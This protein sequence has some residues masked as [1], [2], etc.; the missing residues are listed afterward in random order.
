MNDLSM[1]AISAGSNILN[2][3]VSTRAKERS[4]D[5]SRSSMDADANGK[6]Y[7]EAVVDGGNL[8]GVFSAN[9]KGLQNRSNI[10]NISTSNILFGTP[11]D[12]SIFYSARKPMT[13]PIVESEEPETLEMLRI[14]ISKVLSLNGS[15]E[16]YPEEENIINGKAPQQMDRAVIL[17]DVLTMLQGVEEQLE[18]VTGAGLDI[19]T[20]RR[21]LLGGASISPV[22]KENSYPNTPM[23][24][25]SAETETHKDS[26]LLKIYMD[27][28]LELNQEEL[29]HY[30]K[31]ANDLVERLENAHTQL[32]AKDATISTLEAAHEAQAA[33]LA[34]VTSDLAQQNASS[35]ELQQSAVLLQNQVHD[36]TAR[37]EAT[38]R[39]RPDAALV[40]RMRDG[41]A[42]PAL[43][44]EPQKVDRSKALLRVYM[45]NQLALDVSEMQY[46][47]DVANDLIARL[48][49][50]EEAAAEDHRTLQAQ[51]D[52]LTTELREAQAEQENAQE[53]LD[54]AREE[55]ARAVH[56]RA[57]LNAARAELEQMYHSQQRLAA[58]LHDTA[59]RY[60]ESD[61]QH[62]VVANAL[63]SAQHEIQAM[64]TQVSEMN[65]LQL[66]LQRV[67][68]DLGH[69]HSALSNAEARLEAATGGHDATQTALA[70]SQRNVLVLQELLEQ[71]RE[72]DVMNE[73]MIQEL[74][75]M[76]EEGEEQVQHLRNQLQASAIRSTEVH[77][78]SKKL[79]AELKAARESIHASEVQRNALEAEVTTVREQLQHMA[80]TLSTDVSVLTGRIDV[81]QR[82]KDEA[83]QIAETHL[84]TL[85]QRNAELN[86]AHA[87]A[88][89]EIKHRASL[90][91]ELQEVIRS[92]HSA[93]QP[94]S[95]MDHSQADDS[96]R[97]NNPFVTVLDEDDSLS[98][99]SSHTR[100]FIDG[101]E[102]LAGPVSS[103]D[104]VSLT[105]RLEEAER[106]AAQASANGADKVASSLRQAAIADAECS[107]LK[108]LGD[109]FK[110]VNHRLLEENRVAR[111]QAVRVRGLELQLADV[112]KQVT[113]AAA[114]HE[115]AL[116]KAHAQRQEQFERF[117]REREALAETRAS[118]EKEIAAFRTQA[119]AHAAEASR[120]SALLLAA[121]DESA[122]LDR[123]NEVLQGEVGEAREEVQRHTQ[124][125]AALAATVHAKT[126]ELQA[127]EL[128][129]HSWK[130]EK[131]SLH[132]DWHAKFADL[133]DD[134]STLEGVH[135][136]QTAQTAELRR[137]IEQFEKHAE[138]YAA[139]RAGEQRHL[140]EARAKIIELQ[141]TKDELILQLSSADEELSKRYTSIQ[142]LSDEA[143]SWQ[144]KAEES[145]V[146]SAKL[147][148]LLAAAEAADTAARDTAWKAQQE[149]HARSNDV[150][151]AQKLAAEAEA[152]LR[153]LEAELQR[154][155]QE[156]LVQLQDAN[157]RTDKHYRETSAAYTDLRAQ[158]D[159]L[160]GESARLEAEFASLR[161]VEQQQITLVRAAE[162]RASQLQSDLTSE[163]ERVAASR[164]ADV[165]LS[166]QYHGLVQKLQESLEKYN[167][168]HL[169][170]EGGELSRIA[171]RS[172]QLDTLNGSVLD[173]TADDEVAALPAM[174]EQLEACETQVNSAVGLLAAYAAAL[175]TVQHRNDADKLTLEANTSQIQ[176]LLT[177]RDG[178]AKR[179]SSLEDELLTARTQIEGL[180][181]DVAQTSALAEDS[182]Q[183]MRSSLREW[184]AMLTD[185]AMQVQR[186][187]GTAAVSGISEAL[188]AAEEAA[189]RHNIGAAG[190]GA[191]LQAVTL[192]AERAL[193]TMTDALEKA[194]AAAAAKEKALVVQQ[195]RLDEAAA[196]QNLPAP[197]EATSMGADIDVEQLAYEHAQ[198]RTLLRETCRQKAE[199]EA[200]S[201]ATLSINADLRASLEDAER[202]CEDFKARCRAVQ[203]ENDVLAVEARGAAQ[204]ISE[205]NLTADAELE[206]ERAIAEIARLKAD[207]EVMLHLQQSL[208]VELDRARQGPRGGLAQ[209]PSQ[210]SV[211]DSERLLGA[212]YTGVDQLVAGSMSDSASSSAPTHSIRLQELHA[213]AL[214]S[215]GAAPMSE[216]FDAAVHYLAELRIWAR[217]ESRAKRVLH[218]KVQ[219]SERDA[220]AAQLSTKDAINSAEHLRSHKARQ[221]AEQRTL[222][223][224]VAD[225]RKTLTAAQEQLQRAT[226]ETSKQQ[227]AA[228][229][230]R[231]KVKR[232]NTDIQAKEG[233]MSRLRSEIETQ[234]TKAAKVANQ[235]AA[236]KE[237]GDVWQSRV[238][239]VSHENRDLRA[240]LDAVLQQATVA[241]A[242]ANS[243][244]ELAHRSNGAGNAE[245]AVLKARVDEL[246]AT[247]AAAREEGRG[248]REQ[249]T[250]LDTAASA[251]QREMQ[252]LHKKVELAEARCDT[253]TNE[254][255]VL[256]DEK[257]AL[258][259]ELAEARQQISVEQ[260]KRARVEERERA[261]VG[262][263]TEVHTQRA[264]TDAN[265]AMLASLQARLERADASKRA[266]EQERL[267][268]HTQL[269]QLR[270]QHEH[271]HAELLQARAAQQLSDAEHTKAAT[272][273]DRLQ[274]QLASNKD[275]AAASKAE[276]RRVRRLV[277][278]AASQ[279]REATNVVRAEAAHVG[280]SIPSPEPHAHRN[281]E[282]D[283][284]GDLSEAL[285]LPELTSGL[286][287]LREALSWLRHAPQQRAT[288]EATNRALETQLAGVRSE[289]TDFCTRGEAEIAAA[290]AEVQAQTARAEASKKALRAAQVVERELRTQL[291]EATSSSNARIASA[292]AEV[293]RLR[294][295]LEHAQLNGGRDGE[296]NGDSS[297]ALQAA[298]QE[299]RAVE[300]H[301][302]VLRDT[303]TRLETQ[304]KLTA[305]GAVHAFKGV[306][307]G[308]SASD[309]G[310]VRQ[311]ARYHARC[312]AYEEVAAMYRIAVQALYAD[313]SS[314]SA[315]QFSAL[316]A[317]Q[318]D[319]QST[320]VAAKGASTQGWMELEIAAVRKS[321]DSELRLAEADCADLRGRLRQAESFGAE[322]SRRFEECLQAQYSG[323][324][325]AGKGSTEEA[326]RFLEASMS[327]QVEQVSELRKTLAD[328]KER[329]RR[330]H[331]HIV[332][333]LTRASHE[334]DLALA[335]AIQ[336]ETAC[337]KAGI[338]VRS[339]SLAMA[340]PFHSS[341]AS[342]FKFSPAA[343]RTHAMTPSGTTYPSQRASPGMP[344][345]PPSIAA[346]SP[347][348]VAYVGRPP[349]APTPF[350]PTVSTHRATDTKARRGGLK[351]HR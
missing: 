112:Q 68:T 304:I 60:T 268:A 337:E 235:L 147:R 188:I 282:R 249:R 236:S 140:L 157:R 166:L 70:E 219:A 93:P 152:R 200:E 311:A 256:H 254:K 18:G 132:L 110:Q 116:R 107:R 56:E 269:A 296:L 6:G 201:R 99:A 1:D 57:Q 125:I 264:L 153:V 259:A 62:Q 278:E 80:S 164:K 347:E 303:V 286:A 63:Q 122:A 310:L 86:E 170:A 230:E 273:A 10:T 141:A 306:L 199:L 13:A 17:R 314:Y 302:G 322:L 298:L 328:E 255:Y 218:D 299:L 294:A 21:F 90:W 248:H 206:L 135:Q 288:L 65:N 114:V 39:M 165:G 228:E 209:G 262:S 120:L 197:S 291:E 323:R 38:L 53:A 341:A 131:D 150:L 71:L 2:K 46:Y 142:R 85:N 61:K 283:N 229:D 320:E 88:E 324:A 15:D 257:A 221:E 4:L 73:E 113:E 290:V 338:A 295:Q 100:D 297:A 263:S 321:Y 79:D 190:L 261:S 196:A 77:E 349:T 154:V 41:T 143:D 24:K 227:R 267:D 25:G 75:E 144:S 29:Q 11:D 151:A 191:Q 216:R 327:A 292:E 8:G 78:R 19:A 96:Y 103:A 44:G 66:S 128:L 37:L 98:I 243:A 173:R 202:L 270:A 106:R 182:A 187:V 224:E 300:H 16:S 279:M 284:E 123:Q 317:L 203:A 329:C 281:V 105:Q 158:F 260:S 52:R 318:N 232:L 289:H 242:S 215:A 94:A 308:M 204:K 179:L 180:K 266:L 212:L 189:G 155:H 217:E 176:A 174:A 177:I 145:A 64:R 101:S 22:N 5:L 211:F 280:T 162:Q 251:L 87:R 30:E 231:A 237:A 137:Q 334:K 244:N 307:E 214:A 7:Y 247:L 253:L 97:L 111:S 35:R 213:Q 258:H 276:T 240:Q 178:Q 184:T 186:A 239:K 95:N 274:A 348:A 246:Q 148:E 20:K 220:A 175:D 14:A 223:K 331:R 336:C 287:A 43:T 49:E 285:G 245:I 138:H 23:A 275:S 47:E 27:N 92:T 326:H 102:S 12:R 36:L 234:R 91:R 301:R 195:A 81:L 58:E 319:E 139:E 194:A 119:D 3:F 72:K 159:A 210:V 272:R 55:V 342:P 109:H 330:R 156:D 333:A 172:I 226:Q 54:E 344:Y 161:I 316:Q 351:V 222:R 149:V 265:S 208:E 134:Y 169:S 50:S 346:A 193:S 31:L 233:E 89:S 181:R 45:D 108:A 305:D 335:R 252:I 192:E 309:E 115:A 26:D 34:Q 171:D 315:A 59:S 225:L 313:G 345:L 51:V 168:Q 104:F 339:T 84:R 136:E 33:Q 325:N 124:E 350:Q 277:L 340:A 28:Q 117:E 167:L 74:R 83:L 118:A 207:N 82:E 198:L 9:K 133:Q 185:A 271:Q 312:I 160:T 42:V 205:D 343:V 69:A 40:E 250:R 76:H 332:D 183:R 48:Q 32:S 126:Q 163:R 129:L 121:Q 293:G 238:E 146:E 241:T 127:Q 67:Q 130:V